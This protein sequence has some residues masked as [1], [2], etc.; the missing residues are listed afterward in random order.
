MD[1]TRDTNSIMLS[2]KSNQSKQLDLFSNSD[3]NIVL[4]ILRD[5]DINNCSPMQAFAILMDLKEKAGK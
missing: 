1:I 5:T 4:K 3:D 2:S